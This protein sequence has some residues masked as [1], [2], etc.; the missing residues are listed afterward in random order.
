MIRGL[1]A[2]KVLLEYNWDGRAQKLALNKLYLF[3]NVVRDVCVSDTFS[4]DDYISAMQKTIKTAK[5]RCYSST[6]RTKGI[7]ESL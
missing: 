5:N 1:L 3:S 6:S 4:N 7:N 2:D